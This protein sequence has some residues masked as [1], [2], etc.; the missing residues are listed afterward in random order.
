RS[1]SDAMYNS[2]IEPWSADL[3]GVQGKAPAPAWDPLQFMIEEC[4]KRNIEF[5][6]WLNPYRAISDYNNINNFSVNHIARKRPDWL[7]AS[8]NLRILNPGLPEVRS[9]VKSIIEDIVRRYDVDGIHFDDYFYPNV[10][11]NDDATFAAHPRGFTNKDD[12]RRDNVNLLIKEVGDLINNIKPYVKYGISPSGI[13]R[14]ST[15][16][17]IGTPTAGLQHYSSHYADT[18][19]WLQ[20]GW[21][22]YLTPQV[23]W[24]IGQNGADYSLIVPWWNN[25]S[26][27]RHIYIGLAGYKVGDA[28]LNQSPWLSRTQIP[29]QLRL[30]RSHANIRGQIVYNTKSLLA[31]PLNYTDSLRLRFYQKPALL[32]KMEWKDNT[33]PQSPANLVAAKQ[34]NTSVKLTWQAPAVTS[35]SEFD[36]VRSYA[37]YRST[38]PGVDIEDVGNLIA[39]LPATSTE[40]NDT[41]LTNGT[42]YYYTVTAL[43]R[44]HNESMAS[45]EV[46]SVPAKVTAFTAS[47]ADNKVV[48]SW[49][50]A[51]ETDV[52]RFELLH[53]SNGVDYT[54]LAT[55]PKHSG[56]GGAT[57]VYSYEQVNPPIGRT[58]YRLK[59]Y[60]IANNILEY[61]A[62]EITFVP[63]V[64]VLSFTA[65]PEGGQVKINWSTSDEYYHQKFYLERTVNGVDYTLLKEEVKVSGDHSGK[66]Y[67]YIDED[68][69]VGRSFY[70]LRQFL[71]DNSSRGLD[72]VEVQFDKPTTGTDEAVLLY[73]NPGN[74][75]FSILLNNYVSGNVTVEIIAFSGRR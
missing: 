19:K 34:N 35:G 62:I 30:N 73:P 21:I 14:N 26:F 23:Y 1:Q 72:R 25:N 24:H 10:S 52:S 53:S 65:V 12:W 3:T 22:D 20:E 55:I 75:E 18:R 11:V 74:G 61:G 15:D 44:Y 42:V 43:D 9:Y 48:I 68:P 54:L 41:G 38:S 31:N 51:D 69:I 71:I 13:Y 59:R 57:N 47:Q 70:R 40:Y 58:F 46:P 7:L 5:H 2:S 66:S 33:A 8:G 56:G 50:S 16:P 17:A 39:V 64:N 6:A 36:K 28:S 45:P 67:S 60:D 29:Q 63:P 4:R 27:S 37:V 32:P 49:Q